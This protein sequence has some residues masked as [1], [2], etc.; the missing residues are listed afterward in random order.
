MM[1]ARGISKP[2]Y[3]ITF[4]EAAETSYMIHVRLFRDRV[5]L[6][7]QHEITVLIYAPAAAVTLS[8]APVAQP[9]RSTAA[10]HGAVPQPRARSPGCSATCCIPQRCS[11]LP[12]PASPRRLGSVSKMPAVHKAWPPAIGQLMNRSCL[13]HCR[14]LEQ[15][16]FLVITQSK[17]KLG[18]I[19]GICS[20]SPSIL[21]SDQ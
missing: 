12:Q 2:C 21:T 7:Q 11:L 4:R 1:K 8:Q 9:G 5:E 14:I 15:F 3:P 19:R 20:C 10:Q 6:Q 17:C 18:L 16:D 13:D